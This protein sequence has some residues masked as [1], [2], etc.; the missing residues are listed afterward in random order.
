M[1]LFPPLL[2]L[3]AALVLSAFKVEPSPSLTGSPT[4]WSL[5]DAV[6]KNYAIG[7]DEKLQA[8]Y[9]ESIGKPD[10][11]GTMVNESSLQAEAQATN[12]QSLL[13]RH[14]RV[15]YSSQGLLPYVRWAAAMTQ[16]FKNGQYANRHVTLEAE[17]RDD[18]FDGR[19]ELYIRAVDENSSNRHSSYYPVEPQPGKW[20][21]IAVE[22]DNRASDLRFVD[23][24]P[25]IVSVSE[26]ALEIGLA[27][28]GQGRVLIRNIQL[29]VGK[30]LPPLKPVESIDLPTGPLHLSFD[31]PKP[32]AAP[33][34][35]EL[36]P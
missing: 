35:L 4:G 27:V 11:V 10:Y 14:N 29:H 26:G 8:T 34:N 16:A 17:V 25:K 7:Y 1:R 12:Q 31:A 22:F 20:Q 32:N 28:Q 13:K 3:G 9:L 21:H 6:G 23:G 19:V 36:H 15:P 5:S 18:N 24:M 30:F 2:C 33:V